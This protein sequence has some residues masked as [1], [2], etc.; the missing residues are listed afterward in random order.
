MIHTKINQEPLSIEKAEK[1]VALP[2]NGATLTFV[3]RVRNHHEGN[4]IKA[5]D[6][7]CAPKLAQKILEKIAN[8]SQEQSEYKLAIFIEHF[9]GFL[10]I[11]GISI[12]IAIGSPHRDAAYKANRYIIEEIK[13]R[14]PVW[15]KEYLINGQILWQDGHPLQNNQ[16]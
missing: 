5:I 3:G 12:I 6:Y 8:E 16:A 7:D 4:Q 13:K 1:F 9:Q 15:K 11:G 10:E 2:E 14:L